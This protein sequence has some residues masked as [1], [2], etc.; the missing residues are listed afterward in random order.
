[1]ITGRRIVDLTLVLAEE[2]PAAWATHMPY[3]QKT[4]NYFTDRDDQ[5]GPLKSETG[6]YQT[7]WLLIDEH[8]GTHI[9][10]PAHFIPEPGTGL[11]DAGP[12]GTVTVEQIPLDRLI[13]PAAV[14][15]IADDLPGS[16]PGVSPVITDRLIVDWEA[17]HGRLADGDI[18]LFR[19]G[20]DRHYRPG[21]AGR[22]YSHGPLVTRTEPG[23][24][25][26]DVAAMQL[27]MDRGVRCVGTDGASMGSADNG[28]PVHRLALA[29]GVAFI[30]ALAGLDQLPVRGAT[31]CFA[32][33]KVARG[34]G[35]PGRAF[36]WLPD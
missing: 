10:A 24:P 14:I 17:Q 11:P 1:M 25:A 7:R 21:P 4:F 31:F 35:A 2:L 3:Q 36:A 32:P 29:E 15:D 28:A 8:T 12:A 23:W 30:E 34:T 26:P 13:G 18:V 27:I 6:P 33:L 9:D 5:V 16:A 19:T 20:W 22:A